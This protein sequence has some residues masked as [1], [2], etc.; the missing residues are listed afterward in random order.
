MPFVFSGTP[1]TGTSSNDFLVSYSDGTA[2]DN[3]IMNGGDGNDVLYGDYS[4]YFNQVGTSIASALDITNA[5]Y[6]SGWSRFTN[7]DIANSSTVSHATIFNTALSNQQVWFAVT[8]AAGA[9]ITLDV[10]YGRDTNNTDTDTILRLFESNG[11]T[12]L[13]FNDDAVTL[14]VGSTSTNDSNLTYT[15]AAAGT[16]LIN[17]SEFGG[18]F[19]SGASDEFMLHVSLTGQAGAPEINWGNDILNGG[20]GDDVL[21]GMRGSDVLNGGLGADILNGGYLDGASERDIA[22]YENATTAIYARLDGVAGASGEAV[23]DVYISIEGLRGSS[24]DDVLVGDNGESGYPNTLEGGGGN[25]QLYGLGG[26]DYLNGGAG[27][28][29]LN[30]GAEEDYAVYKDA[31]SGVYARLDGV[32]GSGGEAVGDTFISIESFVG[33]NFDDIFVGNAVGNGFDGGSGED[34]IYGLGGDDFLFGN[35]GYDTLYG[36]DG[37]DT[38]DGGA[39]NDRLYGGAG[40]DLLNGGTDSSYNYDLAC[41][42]QATS[43]V[44]ARLDGVA[45]S[46]GEATGDVFQEIEGL[47]GSA[48]DD[49]LVG[50]D[51]LIGNTRPDNSLFGGAGNDALYGLRGDDLLDGGAGADLLNGG[52]GYDSVDY[53]SATAGVY[54]RLDGVAGASGDALGDT[55]ISIERIIGSN[56]ND[57]F[58]GSNDFVTRDFIVAQDGDDTIYGLNG[59]DV[60]DGEDGNDTLYGGAGADF[61]VGGLGN[62]NIYGGAGADDMRGGD[63]F[64]LARYDQATSGVYLRVDG[65]AGSYGEAAGD[66]VNPDIEGLVGSYFDDIFVGFD[67]KTDFLYGLGGA[68]S[69]YGQG[70][71]D[72]LDGGAGNDSL[73]GGVGADVLN[74]GADFD[75]AR[76][77]DATSGVYARLDGVAGSYGDAAGDTFTAVEGLVGSYFADILV[78][79]NVNGDSLFGSIGADTLY[80]LGGADTLDG[81]AGNDQLYGGVGADA[82]NGGADFDLA[83]YDDAGSSVYARLDGVA[84]SYGDA[85]G[86]TF[87]SIEGLVGSGFADILVGG[88][89]SDSLYGSGGADTLYGL[90]GNDLLYGGAGA[91]QFVFNTARNAATNVDAIMDFQIGSDKIA[92]SQGIFAGILGTLDASEFQIGN[93]DASTDRICYNPGTGQLFYDADGNGTGSGLVLFATVTAGT[94]L[95]INDFVMVA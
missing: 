19:N 90:G 23:G 28:D 79:N 25:D 42:D 92:L 78:G 49:V 39:G 18:N 31:T 68:D 54:A 72:T 64:D 83:R 29:L 87:S 9:T 46:G 73:Y 11:T 80:G 34:I 95:T 67:F 66:M 56:F 21:Y 40:T 44:Y 69:L 22:S 24:F 53:R 41:Y 27:A 16:Y 37:N 8:V 81:G 84:G 33:S 1:I 88:A 89:N 17:I 36:G 15:F 70:G 35:R 65:V 63:G 59:D 61:L 71:D 5:Q 62:D 85:A 58:V 38:L 26:G 47:V 13:A 7:P 20:N 94:V 82:L 55:F 6:S 52:D 91:D 12:Q 14:D 74:G 4:N 30:G 50:S 60:L 45:G 86:D 43:G 77:D 75:L 57:I 2:N 32:A 93:A 76:Y 10:D 48:F 51:L 3:N